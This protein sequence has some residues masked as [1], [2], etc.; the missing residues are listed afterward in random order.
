MK[1]SPRGIWADFRFT[2][3]HCGGECTVTNGRVDPHLCRI[4][5]D[6]IQWPVPADEK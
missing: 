2:C 6:D 5:L 3:V 4:E 1:T